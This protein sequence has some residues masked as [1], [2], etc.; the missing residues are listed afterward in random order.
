MPEVCVNCGAS[1]GDFSGGLIAKDGQAWCTPC[2]SQHL[3]SVSA[4]TS[5]WKPETGPAE[6]V[7]AVGMLIGYVV[8][9][10]W[11]EINP[12]ILLVW[13][14][15]VSVVLSVGMKQWY[16]SRTPLASKTQ[17]ERSQKDF[18]PLSYPDG[19][20]ELVREVITWNPKRREIPF[21]VFQRQTGLSFNTVETILLDL[22]A[23]GKLNGYV[24]ETGYESRK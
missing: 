1:L 15:V 3:K 5:K 4:V 9:D 22:V 7:I 10:A 17:N 23:Q 21:W 13:F 12:F 8:L 20:V 19:V 2:F 6:V 16:N 18:P 14:S 11:Y 24:T